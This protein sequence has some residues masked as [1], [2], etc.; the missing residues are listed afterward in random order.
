MAL[1]PSVGAACGF[2]EE[3]ISAVVPGEGYYARSDDFVPQEQQQQEEEE[4]KKKKAWPRTLPKKRKRKSTRMEVVAAFDF[5]KEKEAE[6]G[7]GGKAGSGK[8]RTR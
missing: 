1:G 6:A 3:Q 7:V 4:K 8:R 5:I 2:T